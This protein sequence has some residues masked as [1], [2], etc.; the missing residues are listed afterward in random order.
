M[1]FKNKKNNELKFLI[2]GLGSMGKRRIRNLHFNNQYWLVGYDIRPDRRR[3]AKKKYGI[4]IVDNLKKIVKEDFDVMIVS[5]PPDQHG[6][7]IK[8]ALKLKKHFFVEHPT[9]DDGYKEILFSKNLPTVKAPSCTLRFYRPIKMIK[10]ILKNGR[11]G[12]ILAFQYHTGQYLPDWHPYEDYRKVYFSKKE[13]G[14]CREIFPFDLIWL[15]WLLESRVKEICGF[16][17]KISDLKMSADDI[18]LASLKYKNGILGNVI[19]DAISRKPYQT[20]RV[21]GSTGTLDWENFDS[22]IKLYTAKSK[23]TE[24]II[25]P[26]GHSESGY[27][28]EEEMYNEEIKTFLRAIDKKIKYPHTFFDSLSVLKTLY[29]LEKSNRTGKRVVV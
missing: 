14:A 10:E 29:A 12:K 4:K 5:T 23:K 17:D 18:I 16:N 3:E 21:L 13:T 25:V 15:N 8:M 9:T 11:I 7:Y 26:K 6:D 28:N 19:I 22:V 20:L 2:V 24:T 1:Q 27:I